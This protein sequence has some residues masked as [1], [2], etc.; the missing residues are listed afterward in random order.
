M[1]LSVIFKFKLGSSAAKKPV[2]TSGDTLQPHPRR[3]ENFVS[4]NVFS[5]PKSAGLNGTISS[6]LL[7]IFSDAK[8]I[9]EIYV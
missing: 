7:A 5:N 8:I 1:L 4:R 2:K 3:S 9:R 6:R